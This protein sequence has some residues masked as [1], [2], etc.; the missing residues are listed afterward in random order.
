MA[1]ASARRRRGCRA[2]VAPL[3]KNLPLTST[4]LSPLMRRWQ[5]T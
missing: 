2:G 1:A 4:R 5:Q 3:A